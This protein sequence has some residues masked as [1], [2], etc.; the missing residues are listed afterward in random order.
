MK[1][2]IYFQLNFKTMKDN[3][4]YPAG[5]YESDFDERDYFDYDKDAD[6]EDYDDQDEPND[7]EK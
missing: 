1:T 2:L 5:V 4:N 7:P 6:F 3:S